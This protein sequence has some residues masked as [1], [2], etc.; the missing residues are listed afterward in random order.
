MPS[1]IFHK[2]AAA[3]ESF[4]E[5]TRD[6]FGVSLVRD[7]FDPLLSEVQGFEQLSEEADAGLRQVQET[8]DEARS[9]GGDG[10]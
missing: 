5:S 6:A 2:L 7:V 9:L 10:A 8:L 1:D 3:R 4:G